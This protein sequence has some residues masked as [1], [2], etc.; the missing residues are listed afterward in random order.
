MTGR[1][2]VRIF[3]SVEADGATAAGTLLAPVSLSFMLYA[4]SAEKAEILLR[5]DINKGKRARGKVYQI[6]SVLGHGFTRSIAATLDGS[7]QHVFLD[8]A[9]GPFSETRR[10]RSANPVDEVSPVNS[11]ETAQP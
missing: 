11:L 1:Y 5:K 8:P 4:D 7:F 2:Q 3:E 9:S 6:C 10:I